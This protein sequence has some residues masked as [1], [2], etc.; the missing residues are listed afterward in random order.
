MPN[1]LYAD[2]A[3]HTQGQHIMLVGSSGN[4]GGKALSILLQ[5]GKAASITAFDKRAPKIKELPEI[6]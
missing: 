5:Y 1:K 2:I 3:K 6:G 4:I